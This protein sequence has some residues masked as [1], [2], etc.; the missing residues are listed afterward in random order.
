MLLLADTIICKTTKKG[1]TRW[2]GEETEGA[3]KE[4]YNVGRAPQG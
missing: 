3:Q 4:L 1:A 2:G